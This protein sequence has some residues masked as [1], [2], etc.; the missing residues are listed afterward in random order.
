MYL[1]LRTT[2]FWNI[3]IL[4]VL[5]IALISFVVFRV[6]EREIFKQRTLS[7][8]M[9]F[10]SIKSSLSQ[11]LVQNPDLINNPSPESELQNLFHR[12]VEDGVCQYILLVNN[13]D[14]IIAHSGKSRTGRHL[15]DMDMR[16]AVSLKT[17]YKK[18][19]KGTSASG[20]QLTISSPVYIK[21]KLAGVLKAVFS[22]QD[23][24]Q[25]IKKA[26]KIIFIYILFDG[27]ILILFGTFL[28]SR[29]LV[30]P[31]KKLTENISEG[32]LD[33]IPLFLSDRNEIGKLSA[34]LKNM[35]EKLRQERDKIQQQLHALEEKNLQLQQAREEI[36][37]SEK[38]ASTGRLAAGIAHEI[39]NPVGIILG[40]IH[41]LRSSDTDAKE[42]SDYL[43]R[44]EAETERVNT[45]IRDLLD[46][47]QPSSQEIQEINLN[48]IIKDTYS[49]VSY[50]KEFENINPAFHLAEELP[51]LYANE[52]QIRQLIVNLV[53]NARDA[54]PNGGTLTFTTSIGKQGKEDK[55]RFIVSDTGKGIPVEDHG[56]LFDPFFTTKEQGKGYG[57]G[58]SNVY[59]IVELSGGSISFSS[60]PGVG[61]AFTITF[62]A[63]RTKTETE[64]TI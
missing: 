28:L 35:S 12:F 54:M 40:Y 2:I 3:F 44:M 10:T 25:S 8:E 36:I 11:I 24:Q 60:T 55:I 43:N 27:V 7:G 5:A 38:L 34:A 57:L 61:T 64:K 22:L 20:P 45:I 37:Q 23:V 33:G 13:N 21:G 9:I 16:Q 52:K 18:I 39:G 32:S 50:Q 29:Y 14:I 58:L 53:L 63:V 26:S 62:P 19:Y 42:H 41:M 4:M 46:Y 17:V 56:K 49:L 47:A 15:V 30:N 48:D 1:S 31:I 51:P 59:R 6:T